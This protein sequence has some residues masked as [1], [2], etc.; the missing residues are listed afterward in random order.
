MITVSQTARNVSRALLVGVL[1]VLG[2]ACGGADGGGAV[3]PPNPGGSNPPQAPPQPSTTTF[4]GSVYDEESDGTSP[5]VGA[6][7]AV[8]GLTGTTDKDGKFFMTNVPV[9][10]FGLTIVAPG[11]D[12]LSKDT[13]IQAGS[14]NFHAY[15]LLP[16]GVFI[17]NANSLVYVPPG[18]S[19]FRGAFYVMYGG[20]G[21]SRPL[22]LGNLSFYDTLPPAGD[23]VAYRSALR[24]FARTKGF[25]V[26]GM[27]TQPQA[28]GGSLAN[29][30]DDALVAAAA[31]SHHPELIGAPLLMQGMST[32]GCLVN[33]V[34]SQIPARTIGFVT[35]KSGGLGCDVTGNGVSSVPGYFF[36]GDLDDPFTNGATF[37]NFASGRGAGAVWA[38]AIER[39]TGHTWVANHALVF[40]WAA[41]VADQRLPVSP[42]SGA[43]ITLRPLSDASGWLGDPLSF[44]IGGAPCFTGIRPQASWFPTEK[45]ARDW[46]SM[47]GSATTEIVCP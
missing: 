13:P 26:V 16:S 11:F 28:S 2:S 39:G 23:V 5:V 45:S 24:A 30:I 34:V 1:L 46:Q 8:A 17:A 4:S 42:T 33:K 12:S 27:T 43:P 15:L 25:A 47:M 36:V 35:M 38:F 32:G 21:D 6:N 20:T 14:N 31:V 44:L 22:L 29:Q 19:T 7:I 18:V 3:A 10:T 40:T 9:G 41:A 37:S